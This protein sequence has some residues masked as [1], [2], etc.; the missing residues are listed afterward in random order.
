MHT[1]KEAVMADEEQRIGELEDEIAHRDRRIVELREEVDELR[2]LVRRMEEHVEDSGNVFERCKETFGMEL[3][4]DGCW[5]WKPFWDQ[6]D[7]L[8]DEYNDLVQRWN[9]YVPL[10]R[11]QNVGRPLAASEA[12]CEQVRKLHKARKSLRSIAEDTGLSLN[13]VRTIVGKAKGTDRAT[14]NHWQRI[15]PDR[16]QA[17]RWKRQRRTGNALPGQAQQA[18]EKGR[19]LVKEAKGLGRGR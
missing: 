19:A 14:K 12:Q 11:R 6:H 9:R 13:T 4:D 16:A 5:T 2:D 1:A 10:I 18:V 3:T 15:E 8:V 17:T 7:A